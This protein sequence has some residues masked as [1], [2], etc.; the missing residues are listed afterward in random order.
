MT[1][2]RK[3]S[4][5]FLFSA[6]AFGQFGHSRGKIRVRVRVILYRPTYNLLNSH[7]DLEG[8]FLLCSFSFRDVTFNI[9]C[10]YAPHRNPARHDFFDELVDAIDLSFPT[11]ICGDFN[12]VLDRSMDRLG[13]DVSDYSRESSCALS[14]LFYACGTT[15]IWRYLHPKCKQFTWSA[16]NGS[17]ASHIDS[18]GCPVAWVPS[19]SSHDTLPFPFSDHCAVLLSG[20]FPALIPPG[21]GI[22]KLN[23]SGLQNDD[24]F[25]LISSFWRSWQFRKSSFVS[26][27]DWWELGKSK[28]KGLTVVYCKKRIAAQ[29]EERNLLLNLVDH[30][31]R[32]IDNG[33]IS[34]IDA[35]KSALS[36]LGE[37]DLEVTNGARET[38]SN[39]FFCLEKKNRVDR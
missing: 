12:T 7:F 24:Y 13:S 16:W 34:C 20:S 1:R 3:L 27:V 21:P 9:S 15:D 30:L 22:W 25:E 2:E 31:K 35:T 4:L 18:I 11:F 28:I 32:K 38:S 19:M 23:I 39:F 26:A 14:H 8:R 17:V 29:R 6:I 10:F 36:N 33:I 5:G 37:L